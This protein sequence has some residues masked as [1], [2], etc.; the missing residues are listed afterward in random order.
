MVSHGLL[1]GIR[2]SHTAHSPTETSAATMLAAAAKRR[3]REKV[4][5]VWT[6]GGLKWI[7]RTRQED[8]EE[9]DM[10]EDLDGNED[11]EPVGGGAGL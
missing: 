2:Q 11:K 4:F 9:W 10:E 7:R 6:E 1:E 8:T 5:I 3:D